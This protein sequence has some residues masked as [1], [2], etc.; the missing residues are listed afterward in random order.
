MLKWYPNERDTMRA[1][2]IHGTAKKIERLVNL[3]KQAL[4]DGAYRVATRLHAVALNMEGKSAPEI[5]ELLKVHRTKVCQW[6]HR[7]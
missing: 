3:S 1:I 4:R 6:F 5:A 7:W 2:K